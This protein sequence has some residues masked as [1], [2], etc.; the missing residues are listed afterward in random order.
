MKNPLNFMELRYNISFKK[1]LKFDNIKKP[2][3]NDKL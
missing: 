2:L 1:Q 3:W